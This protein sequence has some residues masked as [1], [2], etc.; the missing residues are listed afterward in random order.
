MNPA[1]Y[2]IAAVIAMI[3]CTYLGRQ[4]ASTRVVGITYLCCVAAIM[5]AIHFEVLG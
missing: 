2:V 5:A 3:G 1:P 4:G